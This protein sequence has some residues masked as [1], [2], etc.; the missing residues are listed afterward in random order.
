MKTSV[1]V[2]GG[3]IINPRL[4][5]EAVKSGASIVVVGNKFENDLSLMKDFANAIHTRL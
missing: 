3:G 4:A 1:I 2:V 5:E